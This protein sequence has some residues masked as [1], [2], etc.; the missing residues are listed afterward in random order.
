MLHNV[1]FALF[2]D[3]ATAARVLRRARRTCRERE[4]TGRPIAVARLHVSLHRVGQFADTLPP[5]LVEE[6]RVAATAV[7][8][9]PFEIRFDRALSF[10]NSPTRNPFV[11]VGGENAALHELHFALGHALERSQATFRMRPRFTPHLTL[12]YDKR[13]I[14]EHPITPVAWTVR[15]F[16]LVISIIGKSRY[17]I[18]GR[19]TL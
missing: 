13:Q 5:R 10:S 9:E 8:A 4:L 3:S 15:D 2:P 16:A 7:N 19:W 11:L 14:A 6:I 18:V 12:L 17:D 1:F